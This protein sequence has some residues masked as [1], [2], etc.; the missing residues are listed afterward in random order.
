MA[1]AS[2][3]SQPTELHDHHFS[4]EDGLIPASTT[5]DCEGSSEEASHEFSGCFVSPKFISRLLIEWGEYPAV[6]ICF[7]FEAQQ[8]KLEEALIGAG[9]KI[10]LFISGFC[11]VYKDDICLC[12][13][14]RRWSP[15]THTFIC[16]WGEFTP[17]LEDVCNIM[18][19]P[20][21][22]DGNPFRIEMNK[23][24][25]R[26]CSFWK[27]VLMT[28]KKCS[29]FV[30]GFIF[31]D[32]PY[33][34]V[35]QRAFPLAIMLAAGTCFPLAPLFLGHLYRKLDQIS[36]GDKEGAGQYGIDSLV[37]S[38]FLQVWF[39]RKAK[40]GA[41]R[42]T[43]LDDI[44]QFNFRPYFT[45]HGFQAFPF[46]YPEGNSSPFLE[47]VELLLATSAQSIIACGDFF[48]PV[49][50]KYSPHRVKR[51]FGID[52]DVPSHLSYGGHLGDCI[53]GF[54]QIDGISCR[55]C[56]QIVSGR[57]TV[58]APLHQRS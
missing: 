2:E 43:V 4:L 40:K 23:A 37:S 57:R 56:S 27:R 44:R 58:L 8:E 15:E 32:F 26:S 10:S 35:Q 14:V 49:M 20:S 7:R 31:E 9:V 11:E 53:M 28:L 33:E 12:H 51:Q 42:P 30:T 25:R 48:D 52:Q 45:A 19:I 3:S 1:Q 46:F 39:R 36:K 38:F 50:E 21:I 29:I 55:V 54:T 13:V 17:S 24:Q 18:R 47:S 16:S 41:F 5:G 34:N 22:G 6:P